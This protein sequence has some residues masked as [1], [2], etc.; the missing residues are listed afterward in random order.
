MPFD[1]RPSWDAYFLSLAEQV[2]TRSPDPH[3]RHGCVI[4]S[5]DRRVISTGYNGP[6][7]GL[8]HDLV[9]LERPDK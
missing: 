3:T 7:S 1:D 5:D 6:V 9:P 4:V 8:P 2:S